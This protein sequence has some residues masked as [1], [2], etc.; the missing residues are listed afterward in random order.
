MDTFVDSSWYFARFTDPF[1]ESSPTTRAAADGASG[2][3]PVQQYIGGVEH[4]ILHL[5]YSRFFTRAMKATGHLSAVEEPFQ[6]LFTQ[7]MVVHETYRDGSGTYVLPSDVRIESDGQARFAVHV[8]T[9]EK[10]AIGAIEKMSKSKKNVVDP[11]E[12][13]ASYGADTARWFMLSD[14]PPDRDVIWTDEGVQGA[15]RFVQRL[16]RLINEIAALAGPATEALATKALA[17]EHPLQFGEAALALRRTAHRALD[18]VETDLER[19]AFNR[20]VAQAYTLANEISRAIDALWT[21]QPDP[22]MRFALREAGRFLVQITAP[23]MPHL[24]EECWKALGMAGMVAAAP[25][26]V[27]DSALLAQDSLTLPV[28]INGKRRGEVTVTASADA[29]TVEAAVRSL[30]FV[31]RALEGRAIRKVIVVSGRIVNVVG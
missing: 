13:I 19:L 3:L 24:G 5:L 9:G 6:G 28:Q 31:I 30:D 14:S 15:S 25:W 1:N 23:M 12:I 22:D 29:P 17:T 20:C 27:C 18:A 7:G 11:D 16:W 2:W 8:D 21:D 10:I 26:P 4:A